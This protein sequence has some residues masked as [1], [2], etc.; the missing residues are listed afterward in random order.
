MSVDIDNVEE[1]RKVFATLDIDLDNWF[2]DPNNVQ[3][4][5]GKDNRAKLLFRALPGFDGIYRKLSFKKAG[6]IFEL[7]F[8]NET[9]TT[10]MDILPPS[11][12][13][14]T[15]KPYEWRG[16]FRNIPPTPEPLKR[17]W[18][19]WNAELMKSFDPSYKPPK[20]A[21]NERKQFKKN[22]ITG[23]RNPISE[24]NGTHCLTDLLG[25]HGYKRRGNRFIRPDSESGNPGVVLFEKDG[26]NL[27][28]S[29]GGDALNDGHCHDAF[30]AYRILKCDGEWKK[31]LGWSRAITKHNQRM[32]RESITSD[33]QI[34]QSKALQS[35][36]AATSTL[37]M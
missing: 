26:Q 35:P 12:H 19:G 31:A 15:G 13:P 5:S 14:D 30:D 6:V 1:A 34:A 10:Q 4:V 28:Y 16:D 25:S 21:R 20:L 18:E 3:I 24:F 33:K 2:N 7:R 9:G 32:Q 37:S 11:K 8:Q 36:S 22:L 29:H 23:Q 17:L 27:C